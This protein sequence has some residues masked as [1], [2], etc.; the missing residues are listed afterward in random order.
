MRHRELVLAQ[1]EYPE[2]HSLK[3]L[4][5]SNKIPSQTNQYIGGN[6]SAFQ[7]SK[8]DELVERL[9]RTTSIKKRLEVQKNLRMRLE[10]MT[11]F[12]LIN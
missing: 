7:D 9:D 11:P 3:H 10:N 5:H 4:L 8:T 6:Y 1:I 12:W 2:G